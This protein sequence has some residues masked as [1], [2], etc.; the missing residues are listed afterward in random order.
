[1]PEATNIVH[2]A[3]PPGEL[4]VF[5][6]DDTSGPQSR[7]GVLDSRPSPARVTGRPTTTGV[8]G[9]FGRRVPADDE[10]TGYEPDARIGFAGD[11]RPGSVGGVL[12]ARAGRRRDR[13]DVSLR[14]TPARLRSW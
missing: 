11:R 7:A 12:R 5:L 14:S 6:A 9:P 4:F 13:G 10:V 1:M 3:R 2:M 8:E